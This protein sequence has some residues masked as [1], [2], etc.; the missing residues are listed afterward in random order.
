VPSIVRIT[1]DALAHPMLDRSVMRLSATLVWLAAAAGTAAADPD[2]EFGMSLSLGGGVEGFTNGTLAATAEPGGSWGV[3]GQFGTRTPISIAVGYTGSAQEVT[4]LGLD[5]SAILVGTAL[6][7]DARFNGYSDEA[8]SP[9]LFMGLAVR[10]YDLTQYDQNNS[11]V[12]S[13]DMVVELPFGGGIAYRFDN[14]V[15]DARAQYRVASNS[16][17]VPDPED[18]DGEAIAMHRWGIGANLGVEF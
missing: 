3:T 16:D 9:Y 1:G 17:L 15:L 4:A 7:A 6:E 18:P 5:E 10:R 11:E 14:L 2:P 12:R 8:L 13:F